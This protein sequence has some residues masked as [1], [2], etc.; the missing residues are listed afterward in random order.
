MTIGCV[1]GL[2]VGYYSL[3]VKSIK[4]VKTSKFRNDITKLAEQCC[5]Y[6]SLKK[7]Y[8]S[9]QCKITLTYWKDN[10]IWIIKK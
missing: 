2:N 8:L 6:M 10:N 1:C 4:N 5:T 9:H 3:P 7:L